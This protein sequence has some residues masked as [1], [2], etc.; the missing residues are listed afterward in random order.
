[1]T[2]L[3]DLKDIIGNVMGIQ[4]VEYDQYNAIAGEALNIRAD[5]SKA[6]SMGWE[7]KKSMVDT[8]K[9][10]LTYLE[11]EVKQGNIDPLTFM[12]D[13]QIEKVKI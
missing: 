3:N 12:E 9:E 10:T 8:I 11:E 2:T 4:N 6:K 7:P 5:I 13:L 1:M